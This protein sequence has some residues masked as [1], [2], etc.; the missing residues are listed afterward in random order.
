MPVKNGQYVIIKGEGYFDVTTPEHGDTS[1]PYESQLPFRLETS[2]VGNSEMQHVD[3]AYAVSMIRSFI[4]DPTLVLTIR[5]RKYTPAFSFKVNNQTVEVKGVQTEVDAGY[6]GENQIILLE[7]KN[8]Q[9]NNT[10]I[11]QL[12]YPFK[13]WSSQT[14]KPVR[15]VFFE[16]RGNDYMFWQYEFYR[17]R[18]LQQYPTDKIQKVS[19]HQ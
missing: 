18:R 15:L 3:K 17:P 9:T 19:H 6:E 12:F 10:I 11:R 7:A 1:E 8:S 2:S 16:K 5:G 4:G 14:S 13:Q